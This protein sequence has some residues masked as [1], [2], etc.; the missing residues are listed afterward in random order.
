MSQFPAPGLLGG[1]GAQRELWEPAATG[2]G[3]FSLAGDLGPAPG[4]ASSTEQRINQN[5]DPKHPKPDGPAVRPH[6]PGTSA[7]GAHS[8]HGSKA[9]WGTAG[10]AGSSSTPLHSPEGWRLSRHRRVAGP[11]GCEHPL[12]PSTGA[13]GDV[14]PAPTPPR[15][16]ALLPARCGRGFRAIAAP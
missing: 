11:G 15:R 10:P 3:R 1:S 8:T 13:R 16:S 4:K 12:T 14:G 2:L 5:T 7:T 6:H 9:H